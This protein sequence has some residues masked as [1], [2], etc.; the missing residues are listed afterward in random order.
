LQRLAFQVEEDIRKLR[1]GSFKAR[2]IPC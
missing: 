1:Q 2:Q